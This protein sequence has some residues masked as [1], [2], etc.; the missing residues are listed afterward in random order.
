MKDDQKPQKKKAAATSFTSKVLL[1]V[2]VGMLLIDVLALVFLKLSLMI[3][4]VQLL[5]LLSVVIF[6]PFRRA[7]GWLLMRSA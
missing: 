4:L 3:K 5:F 2:L 1:A 6:K 7:L